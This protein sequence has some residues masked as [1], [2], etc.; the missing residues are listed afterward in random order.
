MDYAKTINITCKPEILESYFFKRML[1]EGN[2]SFAS[3]MGIHPTASSRE[4]NRIF[5]LACKAIAHYGLP[6]DAVSMPE[7]SR[8]VVIEG[9]YAERLIRALERKGKV[10][11][12]ASNLAQD[13]AQIELL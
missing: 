12:N 8:S 1:D 6:A 13:E 4:K 2:N 5:K 11:R 10:K 7:N 9:D 3:E